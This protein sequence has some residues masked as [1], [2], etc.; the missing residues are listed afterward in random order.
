MK[1]ISLTLFAMVLSVS[2]VALARA[3]DAPT[4]PEASV[5]PLTQARSTDPAPEIGKAAALK[6]DLGDIL[7]P[8]R[9]RNGRDRRPGRDDRWRGPGDGR[10]YPGRQEITC[11]ASDRGWEEHW[12]GHRSRGF[13][14]RRLEENACADCRK[15]HG[16]CTVHCVT[17]EFRCTARFKPDQTGAFENEIAGDDLPR[18]FDAED[19]ALDRCWRVNRGRAGRCE[20]TGRCD[21]V[22]RTM[23]RGSC[24]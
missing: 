24:R 22:G 19:S 21:D 11:N 8:D 18:R 14:L 17:E 2:A 9:G 12:G 16:K 3:G 1:R 7:F 23:S 5:S 15:K 13:D 20:L 6:I 4:L 10:R